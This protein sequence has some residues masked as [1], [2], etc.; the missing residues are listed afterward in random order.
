MMSEVVYFELGTK[1]LQVVPRASLSPINNYEQVERIRTWGH[2]GVTSF[3]LIDIGGNKNFM[4]TPLSQKLETTNRHLATLHWD[5][6]IPPHLKKVRWFWVGPIDTCTDTLC[7][8]GGVR[9][10][11]DPRV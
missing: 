10:Q 6:N 9:Q 4:A 3:K 7:F 5:D 8:R 2:Q 11:T 1:D